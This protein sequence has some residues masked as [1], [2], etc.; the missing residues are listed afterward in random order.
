ME[1]LLNSECEDG[2]DVDYLKSVFIEVNTLRKEGCFCDVTIE[3]DDGRHFEAH[4]IVLASSSPY[5]R[6]MFTH[7]MQESHQKLVR[8][9]QVDSKVMEELLDFAYTGKTKLVA[10]DQDFVESLLVASNML[11]FQRVEDTCVDFI[12]EHI[13]VKTYDKLR[14]LAQIHP[15]MGLKDAVDEFMVHN[16]SKVVET[17]GKERLKAA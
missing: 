15:Q 6:A 11:Q 16:F 10:K 12:R 2:L 5:F 14:L 1:I 3:C 7:N 4:R 9:R 13:T 17:P 8:I